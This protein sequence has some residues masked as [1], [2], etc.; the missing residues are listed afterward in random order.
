M[1]FIRANANSVYAWEKLFYRVNDF[2]TEINKTLREFFASKN[3]DLVLDRCLN[4]LLN[5]VGFLSYHMPDTCTEI[6]LFSQ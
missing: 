6:S 3:F 5:F 1:Y 4:F 2:V